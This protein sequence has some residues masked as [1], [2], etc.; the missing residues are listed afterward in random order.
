[1]GSLNHEVQLSDL[2][3]TLGEPLL[4][5]YWGHL[6]RFFRT[7]AARCNN[8][9]VV[10]H[11]LKYRNL[12]VALLAASE[13]TPPLPNELIFE[14]LQ[15]LTDVAKEPSKFVFKHPFGQQNG[16]LLYWQAALSD[17][18][19]IA[20]GTAAGDCPVWNRPGLNGYLTVEVRFALFLRTLQS[21]PKTLRC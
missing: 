7:S 2:L 12:E 21:M 9:T 1:M 15:E 17:S 8:S 3:D 19:H 16:R 18:P 6:Y 11:L 13:A 4:G 10:S 20:R 14:V 5:G